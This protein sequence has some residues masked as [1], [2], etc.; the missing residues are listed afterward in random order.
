MIEHFPPLLR[1]CSKGHCT[2]LLQCSAVRVRVRARLSKPKAGQKKQCVDEAKRMERMA[3]AV[4]RF[5][6]GSGSRG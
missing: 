4:E 2:L 6:C 1:P 3:G 5:V